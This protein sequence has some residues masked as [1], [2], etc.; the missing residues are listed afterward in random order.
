MRPI[1][2]T[3]VAWVLAV[4]AV[5][6]CFPTAP[7]T[8]GDGPT[9]IAVTA[10]AGPICP[11]ER[12]PPDPSCAPRPVEG[13]PIFVQ[14]ADGRDILVAQGTTGADGTVA[15]DVPPGDYIV[16][17][18]DV[19]GLMGRPEP[20]TVTLVAGNSEIVVLTYDTGIR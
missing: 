4:L 2:L 12:D 10:I 8:P 15:I 20:V 17:G 18:G 14:P 6:S 3:A 1:H 9:S 11:V 16:P 5:P 13:A 19:E 7:P